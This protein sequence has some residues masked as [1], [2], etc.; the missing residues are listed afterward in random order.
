MAV[1]SCFE[2]AEDFVPE[3]W[4]SKPHMVKNK[5]AFAPFSIGE[6]H[7]IHRDRYFKLETVPDMLPGRENCIGQKLAYVELRAVLALLASKYD[8]KFASQNTAENVINDTKDA[9]SIVPG[10][11]DLIF[12]RRKNV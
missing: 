8:F 7:C 5:N 9:F 1:E 3:R 2:R 12:E 4:Y 10:P 11:L 6:Q